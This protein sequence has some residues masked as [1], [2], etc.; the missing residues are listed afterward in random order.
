[1][2]K[3]FSSTRQALARPGVGNE[4]RECNSSLSPSGCEICPLVPLWVLA[5]LL[6]FSF[7]VFSL[8]SSHPSV[9]L[10]LASRLPL[11]QPCSPN[12]STPSLHAPCFAGPMHLPHPI[13]HGSQTLFLSCPILPTPLPSICHTLSWKYWRTI[14]QAPSDT[15]QTVQ[16]NIES[17][18]TNYCVLKT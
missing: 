9:I 3:C 4:E 1:M 12:L 5:A 17:S 14:T 16:K 8:P 18:V 7:L 2:R 6:D 13:P 11:C 10:A 15:F